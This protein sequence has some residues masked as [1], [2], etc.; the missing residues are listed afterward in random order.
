LGEPVSIAV[1]Q[2]FEETFA[3]QRA[4]IVGRLN[5]IG[6]GPVVLDESVGF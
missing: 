3:D 2:F 1:G 5:G 4:K 6:T